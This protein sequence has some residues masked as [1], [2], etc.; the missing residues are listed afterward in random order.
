MIDQL[1]SAGI[2]KLQA[3]LASG[4]LESLLRIGQTQTAKVIE[5]TTQPVRSN[6]GTQ[7][8]KPSSSPSTPTTS[9]ATAT[10]AV[11]A[12]SATSSNTSTIRTSEALPTQRPTASSSGA[13]P[14]TTNPATTSTTSSTPSTINNNPVRASRSDTIQS[15]QQQLPTRAERPSTPNTPTQSAT[16]S[17]SQS[18]NSSTNAATSDQVYRAKLNLQGRLVEVVTPRPLTVGSEVQIS[19]DANNQISLRVPSERTPSERVPSATTRESSSQATTGSDNRPA[20]T[21]A[22][23]PQTAASRANSGGNE[24]PIRPGQQLTATVVKVV[25]DRPAPASTTATVAQTGTSPI[26]SSAQGNSGQTQATPPQT[27]APAS[28]TGNTPS[29]TAAQIQPPIAGTS[30]P[31]ATQGQA[32]LQGGTRAPA[33]ELTT[34]TATQTATPAAGTRGD[35]LTPQPTANTTAAQYRVTLDLQ[36]RSVDV[37]IP[38]PLP[39]GSEV[40]LRQS[41]Q[42]QL[43]LNVPSG[44]PQTLENALRQH[45]PQQQ[46]PVQLLNFLAEPQTLAQLAKGEPLVQGLIQLLLGR[47]LANPQKTDAG[48]VQ[49]QLQNSGTLLENRLARGDTQA[50]QSDQKSLLLKLEQQL[51]NTPRTIPQPLGQRITQMTQQAISRVLVNQLA[52]LPQQTQELGTESNRQLQLDIPVLWQGRNENLQLKISA[53]ERS[54]GFDPDDYQRRWQVQL[55]FEME[56]IPPMAASVALEGDQISVLWYGDQQ[57]REM[58]EPKLHELQQLL[59]GVGLEVDTLAVREKEPPEQTIQPLR[60]RLI[61][62][63]T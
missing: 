18:T 21:T 4:R 14:A 47:S 25:P 26:A 63:K 56:Q 22:P 53:E 37:L 31:A 55:R 59:E 19:R 40:Q 11:G 17:T 50:L 2:Q 48:S 60:Q 35:T 29:S 15:S 51:T 58:L 52:S 34:R 16:A 20:N 54:G 8:S 36:G 32:L 3:E 46:P 12:N 62:V 61:D 30:S 38:R 5:V 49:Q 57:I 44:Q 28:Q 45:L 10:K 9:T 23:G 43:S 33:T 13:K 1:N 6:T 42:G 27:Y 39:V 7:T 24:L 41:S